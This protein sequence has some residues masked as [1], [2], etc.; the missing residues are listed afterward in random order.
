M[1]KLSL[2]LV[3]VAA[4]FSVLSLES[5]IYIP[6]ERLIFKGI[7][8]I[9]LSLSLCVAS[10]NNRIKKKEFW[11]IGIINLMF[12][13]LALT[14]VAN[15]STDGLISLLRF[16]SVCMLTTVLFSY[17]R[18]DLE[19]LMR[20]LLLF[21]L[22]VA[23][24]SIIYFFTDFSRAEKFPIIE[25]YSNKSIIFEQNVFGIFI[26]IV[27]VISINTNDRF[28]KK[29]AIIFVTLFAIFLSFYRTVYALSGLVMA[30]SFSTVIKI[31]LV[32]FFV[33]FAVINHDLLYEVLK[34]EQIA[35]L[36][37]RSDLWRI[38][39]SGFEASPFFGLGES[40]IPEYSNQILNRYPPFTTYHN[41]FV[42]IMYS[43]GI[44]GLSIALL[45][46]ILIFQLVGS[47]RSRYTLAL[48]IAPALFN[49]YYPFAPNILG[50][51]TGCWIVLMYRT[52][53][54]T[55]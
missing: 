4:I 55:R 31:I 20:Y 45:N 22:V 33:L 26:Y 25:L 50:I 38:G 32:T 6:A 2:L 10:F 34:L 42:D 8:F 40:S 39:Y 1:K 23:I 12:L 16:L 17:T 53:H 41:I 47:M 46:T 5:I 14:D 30:S 49:T 35:T 44:I 37:G 36:T 9:S 28:L 54:C 7:T 48:L 15:N 29:I 24:I 19:I 18:Q 52:N 13:C 43:A 51:I 21:G 11:K 3:L 27:L